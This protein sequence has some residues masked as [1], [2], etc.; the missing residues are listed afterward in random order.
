MIKK[1]E[2]FILYSVIGCIMGNF[3]I[4]QYDNK[5]TTTFKED[6]KLLFI[7]IGIFDT[8]EQMQEKTTNLAYYIYLENDT[9]FTAYIGITKNNSN[10]EKL[11]GYFLN[12]GYDISIEEI[13]VTNQIFLEE[14]NKYEELL[15]ATENTKAI[16]SIEN[17]I[18]KKYEELVI[19]G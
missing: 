17:D 11:K 3:I 7:N 8:I 16:Q 1:M 13:E 12:L 6:N 15:K 5:A 14:F 10:L 18:L 19:S 4:N 2:T 9:K